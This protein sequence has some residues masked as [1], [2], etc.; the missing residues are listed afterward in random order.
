MKFQ[1]RK[2]KLAEINN[3]F[4][5]MIVPPYE[6]KKCYF[7]DRRT[8]T[9]RVTGRA[10]FVADKQANYI[11]VDKSAECYLLPQLEVNKIIR[12]MDYNP[13]LDGVPMSSGS[14]GADPELFV[15]NKEGIIIPAFQF[16]KSK[17]ENPNT[18]WDGFQTEMAPYREGGGH[19][20]AYFTD[21]MHGLMVQIM[22]QAHYKF[23]DARFTWQSVIE[24]PKEI[25]DV[26]EPVH[27]EL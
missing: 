4:V 3:E 21:Q 18:Y 24:I 19:C 11:S 16:L 9:Q 13:L 7:S 26:A 25:M 5:E 23:P 27:K 2:A 22:S 14:I 20:L 10:F 8:D 6:G 1:R 12:A 17:K 15:V